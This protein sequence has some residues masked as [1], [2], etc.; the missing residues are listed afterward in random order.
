MSGKMR[1]QAK[2]MVHIQRALQFGT[3]LSGLPQ[4]VK[5][6]LVKAQE[7]PAD[8]D[9]LSRVNRDFFQMLEHA[10]R[11]YNAWKNARPISDD[12][13]HRGLEFSELLF[14]YAPDHIQQ[15]VDIARV[16][17]NKDPCAL[18][19]CVD[20]LAEINQG[21]ELAH[22][23]NEFISTHFAHV[24]HSL[25][26]HHPVYSSDNSIWQHIN[27]DLHCDLWTGA[28]TKYEFYKEKERIRREINK[29]YMEQKIASNPTPD[30][31][32]TPTFFDLHE[33]L[34]RMD[35]RRVTITSPDPVWAIRNPYLRQILAQ[36]ILTPINQE[37]V[38]A[39]N[40]IRWHHT[41]QPKRGHYG[42][43]EVQYRTIVVDAS[44]H[45]EIWDSEGHKKDTHVRMQNILKDS[46]RSALR[47]NYENAPANA[48]WQWHR[49]ADIHLPLATEIFLNLE[50]DGATFSYD[51]D[52]DSDSDN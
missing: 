28:Y 5:V 13:V 42:D 19:R 20:V 36:I 10:R 33:K 7:L 40:H 44:L 50:I 30:T 34:T 51:S 31:Y 37:R 35:I 47:R 16:M 45:G 1:N 24:M 48:Q 14:C 21:Y 12:H 49:R 8:I 23:K 27:A 43:I 29:F 46:V 15:D 52:D 26:D 38:A 22:D 18:Q 17:V 6:M 4:H 3:E 39:Q 25:Y 32:V 2:A 11:L 41:S 9:K